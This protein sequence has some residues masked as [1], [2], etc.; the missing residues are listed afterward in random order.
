M[1][2][3]RDL[4]AV[5]LAGGK[6]QKAGEMPAC[7]LEAD[8]RKVIERQA[9]LLKPKVS[10]IE[11]SVSAAAPWS[12]FPTVIDE[13]DPI[14]PLAGIATALKYASTDYVLFV[15]AAYAWIKPEV[16][17]LLVARAGDPFDG[18][19]IRI[20]YS[21]PRPLFSIMH[22]RAAPRA[23][24][25]I[26]RGEHDAVGL[27]TSESLAIRWI[28]DF[29]LESFDPDMSTFKEVAT[30]KPVAEVAP[31][32]VVAP[33]APVAV[34]AVA[35]SALAVAPPPAAIVPAAD[36]T[37][38]FQTLDSYRSVVAFLSLAA[39][40]AEGKEREAIG[41][42]LVHHATELSVAIATGGPT[43]RSLLACVAM[44]DAIRALGSTD[45]QIDAGQVLLA[46]IATQL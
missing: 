16:L 45:P 12:R 15:N 31:A 34:P 33:A 25:R 35:S 2:T 28:E 18:C 8:G 6:A 10:R 30:G 9:Q 21:T 5:I 38:P 37:F 19:A 29:E 13:F 7:T 23:I 46:K 1:I 24:A 42:K 11:V 17:D 39:A 22:K 44:L 41:A 27:F 20:G 40:L 4:T 3:S 36:G 32:P 43:A 26:E 14:G